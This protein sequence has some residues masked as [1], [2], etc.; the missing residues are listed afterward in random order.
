MS[1]HCME[2]IR[3]K[4]DKA[5]G[6]ENCAYSLSLFLMLVSWIFDKH[7]SPSPSLYWSKLI[8]HVSLS[9]LLGYMCKSMD[10][11]NRYTYMM[12]SHKR[13]RNNAA[14][15]AANRNWVKMICTV[16]KF[17]LLTMKTEVPVLWKPSTAL[18]MV[19]RTENISRVLQR[20]LW[21]FKLIAILE[22]TSQYLE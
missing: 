18:W 16:I 9:G 2:K 21:P 12:H 3:Q 22:K 20:Q 15:L 6:W 1:H 10:T 17:L 8:P 4:V 14:Q 5:P 19:K 11:E 13:L 7:A